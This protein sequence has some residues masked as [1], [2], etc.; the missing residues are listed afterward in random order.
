MKK[1]DKLFIATIALILLLCA[2][3]FATD[4]A[5]MSASALQVLLKT[6]IYSGQKSF[7]YNHFTVQGLL[8]KQISAPDPPEKETTDQPLTQTDSDIK[9]LMQIETNALPNKE[10][11]GS[12]IERTFVNVSNQV[13]YGNVKVQ[14]R[15]LQKVN[16][17]SALETGAKL[18]I[19]DKSKPS[20]LIYHTHTTESYVI[21]DNGWYPK[22]M[23]T[24]V[25]DKSRNMVRVGDA[26]C[27]R[28]EAAGFTVIHDTDIHDTDYTNAY[29]NS[30]KKMDEIL[31]K[32]PE[33][34]VTIDIHRDSIGAE[35]KNDRTAAVAE[36]SGKK[37][38]QLMIITGCEEGDVTDFP[39]W[40]DNFNFTI[41]L[42]KQLEDMYPGITR[43][44]FFSER[45]YNMYK[46]R[47]SILIEVGSDGNTLDQ[48]V[49]SG[50]LLGTALG[51]YLEKYTVK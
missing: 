7:V 48:A 12:I 25:D 18:T 30:G 34:D 6:E 8:A 47:N 14:N 28:L 32:Y 23:L 43:P 33:I 19:T 21:L 31:K 40:K 50:K 49:Y 46:T 26:I 42:Q 22:G 27:E 20:V 44:V 11:A 36:I 3:R 38:A 35:K 41:G 39:N 4:W 29:K 37:A 24:C 2:V 10:K 9:K 17:K 1:T 51:E 45:R 16:I 5:D 13:Q 15:T